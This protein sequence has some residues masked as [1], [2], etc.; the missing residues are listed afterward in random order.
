MCTTGR[1]M[2]AVLTHVFLTVSSNALS[3]DYSS[4]Q[5][6]SLSLLHW[7]QSEE[8]IK[9][10]SKPGYSRRTN[11]GKHIST[12]SPTGLGAQLKAAHHPPLPMPQGQGGSTGA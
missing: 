4:Q 12:V 6:R 1:L 3:S 8:G 2:Y 9:S 10:R 11:I 7:K 5:Q